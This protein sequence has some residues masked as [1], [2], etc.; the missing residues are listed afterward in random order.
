MKNRSL[1]CVALIVLAMAFAHKAWTQDSTSSTRVGLSASLQ[2][3]QIDILVPIWTSDRFVIAPAFGLLWVEDGGTDIHIGLVPR[4]I[5]YK[6][7]VAAYL[8][9]RLAV[10]IASLNEGTSATDGLVGLA[11]GGECFLNEQ[12]SVGVESQ[13]NLTI[14]GED[15][16]RFGNPGKKN[17]NTAVAVFATVYF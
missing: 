12:F 1:T 2:N 6:N 13:L 3:D 16:E 7:N 4:L 14:S 9:A 15:S 11:F 8:G 5:I 17:L 10:L